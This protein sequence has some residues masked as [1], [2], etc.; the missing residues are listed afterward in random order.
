VIDKDF[1]SVFTRV[2]TPESLLASSYFN[3]DNKHEQQIKTSGISHLCQHVIRQ[4][5]E[6]N[7]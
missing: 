3:L 4:F 5:I 7:V 2:Y 1:R 6:Q